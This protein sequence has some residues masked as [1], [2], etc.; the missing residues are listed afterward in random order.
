MKFKE[1]DVLYYVCPVSFV[2]IKV[3]VTIAVKEKDGLYYI[4]ETG[5]YLPEDCL[6]LD[7]KKAKKHAIK[8]VKLFAKN[9]CKKI[10]ALDPDFERDY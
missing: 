6:F 5:A 4:E 1:G 3:K 2:L 8:N 10:N 9:Y 7:L